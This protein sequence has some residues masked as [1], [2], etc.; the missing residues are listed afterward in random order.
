[1]DNYLKTK[2]YDLHQYKRRRETLSNANPAARSRR[3]R[4]ACRDWLIAN[5]L[6]QGRYLTT[7]HSI[8]YYKKITSDLLQIV[9]GRSRLISPRASS[10]G[11]DTDDLD[12]R[13]YAAQVLTSFLVLL[14][15]ANQQVQVV[16][17]LRGPRLRRD[18]R[19][20]LH[21]RADRPEATAPLGARCLPTFTFRSPAFDSMLSGTAPVSPSGRGCLV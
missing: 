16:G 5:A 10:E 11:L 18:Y 1:M 14:L 9:R 13:V 19:D 4:L 21:L 2:T 3:C 15:P 12:A 7:N 20:G 17:S 8:S 6:S